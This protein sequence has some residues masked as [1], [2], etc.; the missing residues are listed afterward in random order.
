[1]EF[2]LEIEISL[3]TTLTNF[4]PLYIVDFKGDPVNL[5]G[6]YTDFE[7]YQNETKLPP[8]IKIIPNFITEN[9]ETEVSRFLLE[10]FKFERYRHRS[11]LQFGRIINFRGLTI[12]DHMVETPAI[13][14]T[15]QKRI[16]QLTD[17]G[18]DFNNFEVLDI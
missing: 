9:D 10:N 14:G 13:I 18:R 5:I 11:M 2:A 1:M 3:K 4:Q 16:E 12:S 15:I 8:G 7:P 6:Y 17:E